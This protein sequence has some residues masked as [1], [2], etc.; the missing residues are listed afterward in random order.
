MPAR[1]TDRFA[2][3]IVPFYGATHPRLF[4]IERRC[5][6]R[7]GRVVEF[8]D[9]VLPLGRVLD[10]G[11]G[12]GFT[13]EKLCRAGRTVVALE[14]DPGMVA[15]RRRLVWASGVAQDIPWTSGG[16]STKF[17]DLGVWD[18]RLAVTETLAHLRL[19]VAEDRV[20]NVD[21]DGNSLYVSKD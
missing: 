5:M 2:D 9:R 1:A 17:A 4:E 6:D 19:L 8:L 3:Q 7:D 16:G 12:D 20:A 10:V 14:P 13:A 21:M 11:A 18:R 15:A